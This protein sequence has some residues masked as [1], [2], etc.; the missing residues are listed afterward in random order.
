MN[1]TVAR[2]HRVAGVRQFPELSA[3]HIARAIQGRYD[4]FEGSRIRDFVPVLVERSV[5]AE[6]AMVTSADG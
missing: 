1:S 2:V 5:R 3:E 6:L 4:E